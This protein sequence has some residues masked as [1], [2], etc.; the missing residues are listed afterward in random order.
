M[1]E[2]FLI[3]SKIQQDI[4]INVKSLRLKYPLFLPDFNEILIFEKTQISSFIKIGPMGA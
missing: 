1:A 3:V 2:T 4:V